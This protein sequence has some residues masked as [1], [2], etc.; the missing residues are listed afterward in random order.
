M[1]QIRL[2]RAKKK[3]SLHQKYLFWAE[4][5]FAKH[6]LLEEIILNEGSL[7]GSPTTSGTVFNRTKWGRHS[8]S[9]KA[10]QM[11]CMQEG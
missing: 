8:G 2:E 7:G 10:I 6:T 11:F 1:D 3:V 5:L 4:I 9:R